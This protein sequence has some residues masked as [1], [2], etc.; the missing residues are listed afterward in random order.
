MNKLGKPPTSSPAP[1]AHAGVEKTPV[2]HTHVVEGLDSTNKQ[3]ALTRVRT[4]TH[5][6]VH[7]H[8]YTYIYTDT[9]IY[10]CTYICTCIYTRI[11]IHTY[12]HTCTRTSIH[13]QKISATTPQ[14]VKQ[15]H[16]RTYASIY[17]CMHIHMY[18]R[19]HICAQPAANV[20]QMCKLMS[21]EHL[22]N[23]YNCT[24]S[25]AQ[26]TCKVH[27]T[28]TAKKGANIHTYTHMH[29]HAYPQEYTCASMTLSKHA[30][31]R[32]LRFTIYAQICIHID[33]HMYIHAYVYIYIYTCICIHVYMSRHIHTC[34]Y[35]HTHIQHVHMHAH[36]HVWNDGAAATV[37]EARLDA[38]KLCPS[39]CPLQSG[40]E[41]PSVASSPIARPRGTTDQ[42]WTTTVTTNNSSSHH[43][44]SARS[45]LQLLICTS[46]EPIH[47]VHGPPKLR[48]IEAAPRNEVTFLPFSRGF[49]W[50][51]QWSKYARAPKSLLTLTVYWAHVTDTSGFLTVPWL[52]QSWPEVFVCHVPVPQLH[53]VNQFSKWVAVP[54]CQC[55]C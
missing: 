3:N 11:H 6:H 22:Y 44:E 28:L 27:A 13:R 41:L 15:Y 20:S 49:L 34:T 47:P 18:V 10:A 53:F 55:A 40:G 19:I 37:R 36:K 8:V 32:L 16:R 39:P 30:E 25:G 12:T 26:N 45:R 5:M 46:A 35:M 42:R 9:H 29:T 2:I 7:I 51:Y 33:K 52:F 21:K 4:Y 48:A 31:E 23:A 17:I 50:K 24:C 1:H 14:R 54:P 43:H 38:K